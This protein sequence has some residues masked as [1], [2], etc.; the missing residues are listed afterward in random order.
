MKV[1]PEAFYQAIRIKKIMVDG[2]CAIIHKQAEHADLDNQRLLSAHALTIIKKGGLMVHTDDGMPTKVTAHQMV[3]LP[4]GLYAITDLIPENDSFEAIV[5]FFDDDLIQQYLTSKDLS[6]LE[7]NSQH[8]PTRF[9]VNTSFSIF[10][11]QLL[12]LYSKVEAPQSIVRLKLI[13]ALHLI[14]SQEPEGAFTRKIQELTAKPQKQLAH[15]MNNHF[16]KPLD[17]EDYAALLG[18]SVSTFRRDF[19]KQFGHA[20][21][22]WLIKQR[23]TKARQLLEEHNLS[24]SLVAQQAGYEDLPHFIRSFQKQFAITPKQYALSKRN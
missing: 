1:V 22:H 13:E 9:S 24:V 4:K 2:R 3:L 5:L 21:K 7:V 6:I 20:P 12:S 23:L 8:L 10:L 14:D 18:K 19:H 15:F 17:V 16:D 11:D